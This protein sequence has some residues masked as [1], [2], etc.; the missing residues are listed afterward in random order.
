[1]STSIISILDNITNDE[2]QNRADLQSKRMDMYLDDYEKQIEDKLKSQFET[3]NYLVLK[4]MIARYDNVF[5]KIINLKART[6]KDLPKRSWEVD[7]GET[8]VDD[9]EYSEIVNKSNLASEMITA[10]KFAFVNNIC[11][12]RIIPKSSLGRIEY[13]A[14][15]PEYI[16]VDQDEKDPMKIHAIKHD[17]I[18][19]NTGGNFGKIW[20]VWTD[21]LSVLDEEEFPN[22]YFQVIRFDDKGNEIPDEKIPNPYIDPETGRGALPYVDMRTVRG[23]DY[24]SATINEDLRIGTLE[25]N[26][27]ETH[28]NNLMKFS[29]YRQLAITGNADL[30]KLRNAKTDVATIIHVEPVQ[31]QSA[32]TVQSLEITKDPN[33]LLQAIQKQKAILADNHGVSFSADG[34]ASGQRQTAEAMTINRQQLIEMR[35]DVLPLFRQTERELARLTVI[36]ANNATSNYGLGKNIDITGSLSLDYQEPKIITDERKELETDIIKMNQDFVSPLDLVMKYN[37]DIKTEEAA[38]EFL[39]K[40]KRLRQGIFGEADEEITNALQ[41]V[42]VQQVNG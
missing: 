20:H 38:Q 35:K 13:E 16:S 21:G 11:F 39:A 37:P 4:P 9:E 5:K 41:R 34:L 18:K 36:I 42:G 24:W 19:N 32:P 7:S 15:S 28:L 25:I 40:N 29:G 17:I 33:Q 30:D 26:T 31:G 10:E 12:I 2:D 23:V 8:T 22:G 14:V 27:H 3:E 1:M 6:Y